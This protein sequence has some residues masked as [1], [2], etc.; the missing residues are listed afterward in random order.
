MKLHATI[1]D[2]EDDA[3]PHWTIC[4]RGD[5][6]RVLVEWR[7]RDTSAPPQVVVRY[8]AAYTRSKFDANL[9]Q[10][11]TLQASGEHT[12][13]AQVEFE[14]PQFL[15]MSALFGARVDGMAH[16]VR[17]RLIPRL[18]AAMSSTIVLMGL[19]VAAYTTNHVVGSL[20]VTWRDAFAALGSVSLITIATAVVNGLLTRA[21]PNE[22]P[23][24]G[25]PFLIGRAA[26]VT[27]LGLGLLMC[28]VRTQISSVVNTTDTPVNLDVPGWERAEPIAKGDWAS[29][30]LRPNRLQAILADD[31][32]L[33]ITR[34]PVSEPKQE[35]ILDASKVQAPLGAWGFTP[36]SFVV[37]CK[38]QPW[39]R[40]EKGAFSEPFPDD[41]WF[42]DDEQAW[43]RPKSD[44]TMPTTQA[45]LRLLGTGD[46]PPTLGT[47]EVV[48]PWAAESDASKRFRL[49]IEYHGFSS[50]TPLYLR[51]AASESDDQLLS[52]TVDLSSA[53]PQF[54]ETL[55]LP[56]SLFKHANGDARLEVATGWPFGSEF[57]ETSV[58]S[59]K[60][61]G[62]SDLI[63]L[64][65]L[66]VPKGFRQLEK[67]A[68]SESMSVWTH[69]STTTCDEPPQG[70]AWLCI[71]NST[72]TTAP[73]KSFGITANI[74]ENGVLPI[75]EW[76]SSLGPIP[77]RVE[78]RKVDSDDGILGI[79]NCKAHA[80]GA[81]HVGA[82]R[83]VG[84]F[85]STDIVQI[86]ANANQT[87][88]STW[89]RD[90]VD[91]PPWLCWP[92]SNTEAN[93]EIPL[94]VTLSSHQDRDATFRPA[95]GELQIHKEPRKPCWY[96]D[97]HVQTKRPSRDLNCTIDDK[98]Q[99]DFFRSK[100]NEKGCDSIA[101]CT[102]K[103]R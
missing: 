88:E 81:M 61:S 33:C 74:S 27:L 65:G 102:K 96:V 54:D 51:I 71:L 64:I 11:L 43:L 53:Q 76:P 3:P 82:L 13:S 39:G 46:N 60:T 30:L 52:I 8:D 40:L 103:P 77:E 1:L 38:S 16:R 63:K 59:C 35:C 92:K 10:T 45:K 48:Y 98:F 25:I 9:P 32:R 67:V 24:L 86:R 26:L 36:T 73:M 89:V 22:L 41:V 91:A 31:P 101:L 44:C 29:F 56:R 17:I 97:G 20:R 15:P 78:I 87:F 58:L 21:W 75:V 37:H 55:Q 42:G 94:T 50:P 93:A 23:K 80:E 4:R 90:A 7:D 95:S 5:R 84:D 83:I 6:V 79:V 12:W 66:P 68:S 62:G 70:L 100:R 57:T 28:V 99:E 18:S 19:V 14:A 47:M 34:L 72:R 85:S 49:G 69:C 2:G